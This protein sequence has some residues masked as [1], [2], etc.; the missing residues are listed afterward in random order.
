MMCFNKVYNE[1]LK[2]NLICDIDLAGE[3]KQRKTTMS[4]HINIYI[5]TIFEVANQLS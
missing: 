5:E 4:M 3:W 2:L 1:F